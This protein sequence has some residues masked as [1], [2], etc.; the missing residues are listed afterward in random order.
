M[1][2]LKYSR[3]NATFNGSRHSPP[4]ILQ[5]HID[6]TKN[7]HKDGKTQ[8]GFWMDFWS[9]EQIFLPKNKISNIDFWILKQFF[10]L[11]KILEKQNL[12]YA[13]ELW[14][15]FFFPSFIFF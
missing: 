2:Q 12:N 14:N 8:I 7:T 4:S 5:E 15:N 11:K 6:K 3:K 9:L 10:L 1:E 13:F